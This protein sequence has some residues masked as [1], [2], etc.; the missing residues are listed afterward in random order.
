LFK[1]SKST[2]M[3]VWTLVHQ[4]IL[5]HSSKTVTTTP[6]FQ[7][8]K[9]L[10]PPPSSPSLLPELCQSFHSTLAPF[11]QT[12][13]IVRCIVRKLYSMKSSSLLASI[14][15]LILKFYFLDLYCSRLICC[16]SWVAPCKFQKEVDF[17]S[18]PN[19]VPI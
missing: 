10:K 6:L 2:T 5:K 12:T 17:A 8:A 11:L 3:G 1:A 9:I 13:C 19:V 15:I 4:Q 7:L 16:K 14:V 18:F